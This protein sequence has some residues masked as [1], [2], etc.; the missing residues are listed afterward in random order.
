[1]VK[2]TTLVADV[3]SGSDES[4][5]DIYRDKIAEE[6]TGL[7][8]DSESSIEGSQ[9]FEPWSD[10]S[11]E[12]VG[13]DSGDGRQ[14]SA[15]TS[16]ER[17]KRDVESILDQIIRLGTLIRTSGKASRLRRADA[18]FSFEDFQKLDNSSFRNTLKIPTNDVLELRTHLIAYL[19]MSPALYN[20]VAGT[21]DQFNIE[22]VLTELQPDTRSAIDHLVFANLRRRVRF[23]YAQKHAV[24][25]ASAQR[26]LFFDQP[27]S[28]R[29]SQRP[30][31]REQPV[32][33]SEKSRNSKVQ[34]PSTTS[35]TIASEG[36]IDV[37]KLHTPIAMSR[38]SVSLTKSGWPH[39]PLIHDKRKSFKCPCCHMTL[40]SLHAERQT[41]R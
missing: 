25:L 3:C 21:L 35:G 28:E 29:G 33:R 34:M 30:Q 41:W 8:T 16:I 7:P 39:P 13:D 5:I 27:A 37:R 6:T 2:E 10:E 22:S 32:Q 19:F 9:N 11:S 23:W 26:V 38:M 36:T 15:E 40:S 24:K 4:S 1:M 31:S 12:G 18:H 14:D 20:S 17:S